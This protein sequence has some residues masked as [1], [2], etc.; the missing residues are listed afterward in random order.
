[1]TIIIN[2]KVLIRDTYI[3]PTDRKFDEC[4]SEILKN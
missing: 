3:K 4:T 1:M 2:N